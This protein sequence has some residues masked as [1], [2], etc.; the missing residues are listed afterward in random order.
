MKTQRIVLAAAATLASLPAAHAQLPN[1]TQQ[2]DSVDQR[3]QLQQSADSLGSTNVPALYESET[4]DVGPQSVLQMKARRKWIEAYGD[5]QYFYTDNMFL[6][7]SGKQGADVLVST[8]QAALAPS[9]YD[10][11]GGQLSPRVGYQQQWFTFGLLTPDSIQTYNF[12]QAIGVPNTTGLD[13]Y[14]FNVS[15]VFGDVA[16]RRDNWLFTL[17]C[18]FRRLL[19]SNDYYEFYREYSPRWGVRRDFPLSPCTA[20]SI[21]YDGDYRAT[22]TA[23]PVPAGYND[24]FNDRT[25]HA[26]SIV[27]SWRLCSHAILQP[28]YRFEYSHYTR[29]S[30][31]DLFHSFGLTLYCPLNKNVVLRTFVGYDNMH[32]D[33]ALNQSY[34][35]LDAGAGLNLAV[36]F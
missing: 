23:P 36:Q 25:D 35:K 3:R 30:R 22:R 34:Q 1:A 28:Y 8:V 32:T 20:I 24:A 33:G 6:A 5:V 2:V 29:I 31:D 10:F 4:S 13:I 12:N 26:L 7:N 18:D 19:T 9:A 11:A 21:G 16:W 14:D 15:T 27:G 17:G